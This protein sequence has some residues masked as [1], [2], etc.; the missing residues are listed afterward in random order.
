MT[1]IVFILLGGTMC[2]M[3]GQEWEPPPK[4]APH[5]KPDLVELI[6]LDPTFRL[7]VRYAT[8]N[9]FVGRAV[10][11]GGTWKSRHLRD[12][13]RSTMEAKGFSP[14]ELE[15]WHYHYRDW[16]KYPVLDIPFSEIKT[17]R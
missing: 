3:A 8:T 11:T 6:K 15:W 5:R 7:D 12:L 10:Y 4:E 2:L 16:E 1:E 14:A 9:N 17:T 13:L